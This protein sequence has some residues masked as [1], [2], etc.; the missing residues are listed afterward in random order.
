MTG[1]DAGRAALEHRINAHRAALRNARA[2][3][4]TQRGPLRGLIANTEAA[5]REAQACLAAYDFAVARRATL[6][7]LADNDDVEA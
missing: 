7:W 3:P 5:L 2:V 6:D 4:V 1:T